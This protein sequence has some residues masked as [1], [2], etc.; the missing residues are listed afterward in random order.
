MRRETKI[1]RREKY[2]WRIM[3]QRDPLEESE[4]GSERDKQTDH[5]TSEAES[6]SED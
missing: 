2:T 5:L 6:K 4:R 3:T 1:E